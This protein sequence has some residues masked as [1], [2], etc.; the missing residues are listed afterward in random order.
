MS[1]NLRR[2][3]LININKQY[4]NYGDLDVLAIHA[5]G[6]FDYDTNKLESVG[7]VTTKCE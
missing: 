4:F 6:T 1:E 3:I 7:L 5:C 2:I